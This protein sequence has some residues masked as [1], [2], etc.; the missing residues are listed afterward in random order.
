MPKIKNGPMKDDKIT[1]VDSDVEKMRHSHYQEIKTVVV[2]DLFEFIH[3]IK[4]LS[5]SVMDYIY[6]IAI[7]F[8][9][10]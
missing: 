9:T 6:I 1:I 8:K 10:F 4:L 3:L 5:I 2:V 7:F